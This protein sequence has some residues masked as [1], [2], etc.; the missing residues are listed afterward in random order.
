[1]IY[2][3][4][5]S[6]LLS[7]KSTKKFRFVPFCWSIAWTSTAGRHLNGSQ[8]KYSITT[9]TH[10][11]NTTGMTTLWVHGPPVR[12]LHSA[13]RISELLVA[14]TP[15]GKRGAPSLERRVPH[16]NE[17]NTRFHLGR[18]HLR[19]MWDLF[20]LIKVYPSLQYTQ[21]NGT[22]LSSVSQVRA[23]SIR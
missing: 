14:L 6:L 12:L 20:K 13:N 15:T 3:T 21:V 18:G 23:S 9:Q 5:Y 10:Y 8:R 19:R 11:K 2:W 4:L 22:I 1:M 7:V 16:F 17:T